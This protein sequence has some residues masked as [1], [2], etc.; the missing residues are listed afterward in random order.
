MRA[1]AGRLQPAPALFVRCPL[2]ILCVFGEFGAFGVFG[3]FGEF[4]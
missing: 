2:L 4:W 3:E 1:D